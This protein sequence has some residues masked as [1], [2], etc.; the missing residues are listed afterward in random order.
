MERMWSSRLRWRLRGAWLWPAFVALTLLDGLLLHLRPL[1]GQSTGLVGGLLLAGFLNLLLVA[2]GAPLAGLLL[3]RRRRDLP[4]VVAADYA[5]SALLV[6]LTVAFAVIGLAHHGAV[7]RERRAAQRAMAIARDFT[8]RAAP[9]AVQRSLAAADT[10]RIDPGRVY[11]SCVPEAA[12][13]SWCVVVHLDQRPP[14]VIFDGH[15]PNAMLGGTA[16]R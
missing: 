5:G 16:G 15:E 9:P 10:L 1:Q 6:G 4:R 14:R 11:R 13:R 12:D 7:V 2:V 3:R 8:A